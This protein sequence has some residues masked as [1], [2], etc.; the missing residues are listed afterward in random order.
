MPR[1]R[2][3][4]REDV[5]FIK[6][7]GL[8]VLV[9][10]APGTGKTAVAIRAVVETHRNSLPAIVVCPASVTENWAKEI[11]IWAPG[12][13]SVIVES[14]DQRIYAPKRPT[15]FILSWALLDTRWADLL[16]TG[17]K[18]V[19]ADECHWAKNRDTL[20]SQ[21]L[22]E[23]TRRTNGV[24]LLSGTPIVNTKEEL[25][26]LHDL[27]GK[28]D[29]PMIRRL[30]EDVAPDI[31]EKK[32]SFLQIQMRDSDRVK[33][34][35]ADKDFETW[36]RDEKERLNGEGFSEFEVE[37]TLAAEAL[38]KI[39]Y[40]RRLAGAGKVPAALDFIAQA[41]RIGE[42][43]VVFLEHQGVLQRL[44]KGLKKQRIRHVVIEGATSSKKRQLAVEAFQNNDY[45]VFIGTKAAKEG[46]TLTAARHLLFI[47]R[48]W[49]SADEEQAEDRIRRIGQ[50]HK[51]TIWYLHANDTVD[52]RVDAIVST[53]RTLIRSAIGSADIRQTPLSNVEAMIRM[54]GE[55]AEAPG[56]MTDLGQNKPLP[57]LPRPGNT[58]GVVF[59]G[60]RWTAKTAN[61]WCRMN[62]YKAEKLVQLKG[63]IKLVVHPAD[64]FRKNQFEL[65]K[66]AKDINIIVGKRLSKAN[67]KRVRMS[68]R[69]AR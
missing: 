46:I 40:L 30:L 29:P 34:D 21:A 48:F 22:G 7:H 57:S 14:G 31:P 33:Y 59:R 56:T 60:D 3:F 38:A 24:L 17:A 19:I 18:T 9:A 43:V 4:Q 26:V 36:L 52:D 16:R 64:V 2:D 27:L 10:S 67:E 8:R 11:L 15:I 50:K 42:P 47:E 51:T 68:L 13:R 28:E 58:H 20:R 63:R 55:H 66:V 61:T 69:S 54:W 41:V 25:S 53:K 12:V 49:T 45:P 44:T 65:V 5:D 6:R 32:R 62:G 35:Q 23:I 37:R 1:L 39:G